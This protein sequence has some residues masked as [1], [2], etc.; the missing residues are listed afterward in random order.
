ML[1][2]DGGGRADAMDANG[3]GAD[4]RQGALGRQVKEIGRSDVF[5]EECLAHPNARSMVDVRAGALV[6]DRVPLAQGLRVDRQRL[7]GARALRP[8]AN[9]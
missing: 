7:P 3:D 9:R 2:T 4:A 8:R 6:R 5:G 1:A